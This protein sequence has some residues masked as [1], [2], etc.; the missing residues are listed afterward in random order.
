MNTLGVFAILIGIALILAIST[1][2]KKSQ[3]SEKVTSDT[4]SESASGSQLGKIAKVV[5]LIIAG[6]G[7]WLLYANWDK[8][9]FSDDVV[10][11]RVILPEKGGISVTNMQKGY[12]YT[13]SAR[14]TWTYGTDDYNPTI[15]TPLMT[16]NC[17]SGD[18]P[19]RSNLNQ[20][21]PKKRFGNVPLPEGQPLGIAVFY[22][23]EGKF[24]AGT[25]FVP[26]HDQLLR[27]GPNHY[28]R[29]RHFNSKKTESSC[30]IT[31]TRKRI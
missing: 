16:K 27:V 12:E 23:D 26:T 28:Q 31:V 19:R 14:G 10:V 6:L 2:K 8:F 9:G 30:V 25:V 13:F 22:T 11:S 15:H 21:Y 17:L 5:I 18:S 24:T 1:G 20:A 7:I 4:P 29:R 3:N